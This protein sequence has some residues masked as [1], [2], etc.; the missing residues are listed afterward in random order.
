M[1][2]L[3]FFLAFSAWPQN[4]QIKSNGNQNI[5]VQENNGLIIQTNIGSKGV[6]RELQRRTGNDSWKNVL[7]PAKDPVP[8]NNCGVPSGALTVIL[9]SF[10]TAYCSKSDCGIIS[11][12]DNLTGGP[13]SLLSVSRDLHKPDGSMRVHAELFDDKGDIEAAIESNKLLRNPQNTFEWNR[14][15]VHELEVVDNQY[16]KSLRIRFQNPTTLYVEGIFYDRFHDPLVINPSGPN[17]QRNCLGENG[18]SA[19]GIF[20]RQKH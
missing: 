2:L 10:G 17:N 4:G 19:I 11:G 7:L 16:R 6:Q 13:M 20:P 18:F 5:N 9:G 8:P 3:P 15:N 1:A 14:P 12:M